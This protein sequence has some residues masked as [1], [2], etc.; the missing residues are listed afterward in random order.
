MEIENVHNTVKP[1]IVGA[2]SKKESP[3]HARLRE[4]L[5]LD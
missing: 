5:K 4:V 2:K 3:Q 1:D